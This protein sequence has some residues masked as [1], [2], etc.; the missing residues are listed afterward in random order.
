MLEQSYLLSRIEGLVYS[1][2]LGVPDHLEVE[3]DDSRL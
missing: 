1:K 2:I 3:K